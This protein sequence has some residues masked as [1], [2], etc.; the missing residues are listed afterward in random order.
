MLYKRLSP[1]KSMNVMVWIVS[2]IVVHLAF[3]GILVGCFTCIPTEKLL[4]IPNIFTDA[5]I[6]FMPMHTV[7]GLPIQKPRRSHVAA[8]T[9]EPKVTIHRTLVFDI[10]RLVS[11]IDLSRS[12]EDITYN[13]VNL[14]V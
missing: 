9:L 6:L 3:G 4:Q 1:V 7:W 2:A 11:L 10:V 8:H 5:M 13:Q 14:S 12:G